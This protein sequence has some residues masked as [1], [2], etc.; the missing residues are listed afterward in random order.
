M[1]PSFE[2][3]FFFMLSIV[4]GEV[5]NKGNAR[6]ERVKG[7]ETVATLEE[8]LSRAW[9]CQGVASA[10]LCLMWAESDAEAHS[11]DALNALPAAAFLES[12]MVEHFR[13]SGVGT[14]EN[15]PRFTFSS[16]SGILP[17]VLPPG[18][19]SRFILV[20]LLGRMD[21]PA[22]NGSSP[23]SRIDTGSSREKFIAIGID[24][25]IT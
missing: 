25:G 14:S 8:A 1:M 15:P 3:P 2:K 10:R 11:G 9:L 12:A 4:G 5:E 24:F 18:N 7:K 17:Q 21:R 20:Y 19:T 16:L 22:V 23:Q 6:E 13:P